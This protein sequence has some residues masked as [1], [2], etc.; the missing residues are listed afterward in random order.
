MGQQGA[1]FSFMLVADDYAMS[2]SVSRGIR[3]ALAAE[4]LSG[5]GAM[6]NMPNWREAARALEAD[7]L[8]AKA[9][10]HL[11]LTCGPSATRMAA[12]AP[13]GTLP[14]FRPVWKGGLTRSLPQKELVAEIK[15]QLD[16][17]CDVLG[18]LPAF[19]DGH[20]HVQ[21]LPQ[22]RDTLLEELAKR[23]WQ[24]KVWLRNSADRADVI[25]RR[26]SEPV[27]AFSVALLSRGFAAA[28]GRAGF[29]TNRGFAG[30]SSFDPKADYGADFRRY[31]NAPGERHLV[32]CHP[33][34]AD[35]DLAKVDPNTLSRET[36][37]RFLLSPRFQ[38]VLADAGGVLKPV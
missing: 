36:E 17:F 2:P 5:T 20:Q 19:V 4:R 8:A 7:G 13:S 33:G 12:L 26:G 21:G 9:G 15:A 34:Y 24:G 14:P 25:L 3:E 29:S 10:V 6:T 31:L 37:L 32:M 22:V 28:A 1:D 18:R 11:N 35:E 16:L 27:K 38:D 23:G 30:F